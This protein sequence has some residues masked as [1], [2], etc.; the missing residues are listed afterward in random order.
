MVAVAWTAIA[1]LAATL[2]VLSSALLQ[3]GA[4]VDRMGDRLESRIDQLG[5][6]LDS[7]IDQL[8]ARLTSRIDGLNARLDIHLERHA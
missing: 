5:G 4:K 3:I 7:R 1:L 6:R 2:G 8:D